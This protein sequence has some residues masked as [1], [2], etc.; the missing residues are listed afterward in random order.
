M[1]LSLA[2]VGALPASGTLNRHGN[3]LRGSHSHRVQTSVRFVP[4]DP[5]VAKRRTALASHP[6][7][8]RTDPLRLGDLHCKVSETSRKT[9]LSL[10]HEP[11]GSGGIISMVSFVD[12]SSSTSSPGLTI[13]QKTPNQCHPMAYFVKSLFLRPHNFRHLSIWAQ[14]LGGPPL[15]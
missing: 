9:S 8:Q 3:S 10:N 6:N 1:A 14:I 13:P 2:E 5:F 15:T 11:S 7:N 12:S 4:K